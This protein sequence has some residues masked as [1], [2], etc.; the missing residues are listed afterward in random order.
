MI[1][2]KTY[3]KVKDNYCFGY[4]GPAHEYLLQIDM[5]RPIIEKHF[6]GINMTIGC[7]SASKNLIE[8]ENILLDI[9]IKERK[10]D[11][12]HIYDL[13]YDNTEEHPIEK[14]LK[15]CG[16]NNYKI[17]DL[18]QS[19]TSRCVITNMANY[20][21][22]PMTSDQIKILN[23]FILAKG[24]TI[25]LEGKIENAGWVVGVESV[26]L[27]QAAKLGIKTSLVPTGVGAGLYKK[28]FPNGEILNNI[29]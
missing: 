16:I 24:F 7:T 2:L 21:T 4:F 12:G 1:E 11:F 3:S 9:E 17:N 26:K 10:R 5:L 20:P 23:K 6:P 28:M 25:D 8:C 13:R 22:K 19:L 27:F 18:S 14:Y 15:D 29:A